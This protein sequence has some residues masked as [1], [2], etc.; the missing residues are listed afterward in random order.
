MKARWTVRLAGLVVLAIIPLTIFQPVLAAPS[1]GEVKTVAPMWGNGIPIPYLEITQGSDWM[2][3]LY[4]YLVFQNVEGELAPELSLAH[5]WEMSP[6]GL[7]WTFYIRKGVKFHDG[8]ELTAKD[9][10]FS[11]ELCGLPDSMSTNSSFIRRDVK[12]IEV[13]DSYTVVIHCKKPAIFLPDILSTGPGLDGM[14]VPKDY[15]EKVGRDQFAKRPIGTG[16]YKWHSQLAGSFI[17]LEATERHW[18]YGVPKYKYMTYLVIPEE[19]TQLAMLRAG[20]ADIARI[21][22]EAV[23]GAMGAGLNIVTKANA[24]CVHFLTGAQWTSPVFSDIRFRKALNLAVDKEAIIKHIF[25]GMARRVVMYPGSDVSAIGGDQGLKPYPYDPKEAARLIKEGGWE[26]YEFTL[27]S[28][29]RAG[30]PEFPR[31]VETLAGY[32]QKIGL[33]PKILMTEYGSWR[34][35]WDEGKTQNQVFGFDGV[36]SPSL[37]T[38]L[39]KFQD[40][41]YARNKRSTVNNAEVNERFDRINKSLDTAEVSKL[42]GEIWRWAYDQYAAIPI[43]EIPYKIAT[44]KRIPPWDPGRRRNDLNYLGLIKQ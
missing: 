13:K 39:P 33:R 35:L 20:E 37:D 44:T 30:C 19:S 25:E 21:S 27:V 41:W 23:K 29:P 42:L 11:L 31:V 14:I 18:L 9:V 16:P 7:T 26:G 4:D 38:L 28:Y 6:D 2:H 10:K 5:K 3:L 17:K 24:A 43:C 12:S 40:R 32:W 34:K 22:A 1:S 15:Y 8:V 36:L